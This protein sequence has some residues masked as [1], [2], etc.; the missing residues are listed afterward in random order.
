MIVPKQNSEPPVGSD[1]MAGNTTGTQNLRR[2]TL[3]KML[4]AAPVAAAFALSEAE[5][6]EAHHLARAALKT[7]QQSGTAYT[8]KFFTEHEYETV[9]ILSDLIIPA[10]DRSGAR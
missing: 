8:P 5:A 10:D 1:P 6:H 2:R 3:L 7:A 9:K 4:S